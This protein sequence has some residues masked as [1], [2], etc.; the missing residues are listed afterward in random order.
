LRCIALSCIRIASRC[1]ASIRI[2]S[3][4]QQSSSLRGILLHCCC[5]LLRST[6]FYCV[7]LRSTAFYCVLLRS[8][9]FYCV[10]LSC[11]LRFDAF[12]QR[13]TTLILS[14]NALLRSA[15]CSLRSLCSALQ[16]SPRSAAPCWLRSA[17]FP[18]RSAALTL[19]CS[20]HR[21]VM[22]SDAFMLR[23]EVFCSAL[24]CSAA[25]YT[26]AFCS[27]HFVLQRSAALVLFRSA[28]LSSAAAFHCVYAALTLFCSALL[29][30]FGC[31][32]LRLAAFLQRSAA[33]TLS[34]SALL[35]EFRCVCAALCYALLAEFRC[36]SAALCYALLAE[37]R[38]VSA[39]LA[40][41]LRVF[42]V[43]F[44]CVK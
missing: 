7:L 3:A 12:M 38:C 42:L 32:W 8:T 27:A 28:R 13:S 16:R 21:A 9:A 22:C 30:A 17:A 1:I 26:A 35:A 43:E 40:L 37:F 36:V 23:S 34:C 15:G 41:F 31:V 18:Q 19:F 11:W 24:H 2:C 6:A 14:C 4:L 29:A 20:T 5:S 25:F 39:A 44:R 10:L 33:L